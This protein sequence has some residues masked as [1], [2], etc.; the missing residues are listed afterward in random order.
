MELPLAFFRMQRR[1]DLFSIPDEYISGITRRSCLALAGR[2]HPARL[3][4][5]LPATLIW[6]STHL[7]AEEN[8]REERAFLELLR[9]TAPDRR[10]V[11]KVD[12]T[13]QGKG[14]EVLL[15][16]DAS[17]LQLCHAPKY[18]KASCVGQRYVENPCL[19][20]ALPPPAAPGADA[21]GAGEGAGTAAPI[22]AA[23]PPPAPV[24]GYKWDARIYLLVVLNGD[25][26]AAQRVWAFQYH[27]GFARRCRAGYS[28]D[29]KNRDAHITNTA[30]NNKSGDR[31]LLR[32]ARALAARLDAEGAGEAERAKH[33]TLVGELDDYAEFF[34][35]LDREEASGEAADIAE[36]E[37]ALPVT[38]VLE[39]AWQLLEQAYGSERVARAQ[40]DT[41][42]L[43]RDLVDSVMHPSLGLLQPGEARSPLEDAAPRPLQY[44]KHVLLAG[45][46]V[47]FDH[48]LK[49][50]LL[51]VNRFPDMTCYSIEQ[52][53]IKQ[54]LI[55]D[56][57]LCSYPRSEK[58]IEQMFH[59]ETTAEQMDVLWATV[60]N[61]PVEEVSPEDA[62]NW[63]VRPGDRWRPLL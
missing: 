12:G 36:R 24:A 10:L 27:A 54:D 9:T 31:A 34:Q 21:A 49:P 19:L 41:R 4:R 29:G 46:D 61:P 33:P 56:A 40:A 15:G 55:R 16:G 14:V 57:V 20:P 6:N 8:A 23:S 50:W 3:G 58:H 52:L 53:A 7:S 59:H 39:H 62:R 22:L 5:H 11:V 60:L 25:P 63:A 42:Q 51:E 2:R 37:R 30:A 44:K 13:S 47:L 38:M 45:L 43:M 35:Q 18:R 28:A 17:G 32:Y 1:V 26:Q 48:D